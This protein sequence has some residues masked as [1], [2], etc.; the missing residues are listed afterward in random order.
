MERVKVPVDDP[1]PDVSQWWFEFVYPWQ[2]HDTF[3]VYWEVP[4]YY[5][6]A[7]LPKAHWPA[8]A[9]P[10]S[11]VE[12]IGETAATV[13]QLN[14]SAHPTIVEQGYQWLVQMSEIVFAAS[15]RHD[16]VLAAVRRVFGE[17]STSLEFQMAKQLSDKGWPGTLED[18]DKAV[19]A[20]LA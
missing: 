15:Q 9:R 4:E 11:R 1:P 6:E 10:L 20:A 16:E 2:S 18:L 19:R 7:P 3:F 8:P 14:D 13:A 12:A 17:D 5:T